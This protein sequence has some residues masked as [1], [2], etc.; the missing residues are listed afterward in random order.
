VGAC[1]HGLVRLEGLV[2]P[3]AVAHV[4]GVLAAPAR[5]L[6]HH[7]VPDQV[8]FD[9]AAIGILLRIALGIELGSVLP[10]GDHGPVR[11]RLALLG[12]LERR[13]ARVEL[14]ELLV[15]GA[16]DRGEQQARL[17]VLRKGDLVTAGADGNGDRGERYRGGRE[18]GV[19]AECHGVTPWAAA[20][21]LPAR[22]AGPSIFRNRAWR[23]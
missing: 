23:L 21:G 14:A 17:V 20:P 16:I 6:L 3:L 19:A 4:L 2:L 12:G 13:R 9:E 1:V 11:Q 18:N 5:A 7:R 22:A 10:H 8:A 15:V